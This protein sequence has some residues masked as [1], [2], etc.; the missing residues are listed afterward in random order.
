MKRQKTVGDLLHRIDRRNL[1]TLE[2]FQLESGVSLRVNQAQN[3]SARAGVL[4]N[5]GRNLRVECTALKHHQ[6]IPAQPFSDGRGVKNGRQTLH[7][8][9]HFV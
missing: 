1:D 4:A 8:V 2:G 6:H 5:L 3:G 7:D 9:F